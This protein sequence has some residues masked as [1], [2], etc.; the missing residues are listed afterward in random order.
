M[1]S[2]VLGTLLNYCK[3]NSDSWFI[4][5]RLMGMILVLLAGMDVV[6][7]IVVNQTLGQHMN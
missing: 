3:R 2:Q 5:F 1:A 7:L 4:S 6:L